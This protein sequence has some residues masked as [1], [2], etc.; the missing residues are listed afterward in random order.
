MILTSAHGA[1]LDKTAL[2]LHTKVSH[3]AFRHSWSWYEQW[4]D[5]IHESV[6]AELA[7]EAD[8]CNDLRELNLVG[9]A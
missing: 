4:P 2:A 8:R 9:I 7:D 1:R 3:A 6:A 5:E